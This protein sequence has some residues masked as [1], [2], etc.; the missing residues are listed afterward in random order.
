MY[1]SKRSLDDFKW[2]V[3]DNPAGK[4]IVFVAL[5]KGEVVGMQSLVP[6]TFL[7]N[8]K[9][10]NT[11]KS[12]D[13]LVNKDL[14]GQGIFSKLYDMVH[15]YAKNTLVWGLTDKK[16]ILERVDMPS[17]ER[18]TISVAVKRPLWVADRQG[19][20]QFVAKTLLYTYFYL[21]STFKTKSLPSTF[22]HSEL[23]VQDFG[24]RQLQHFFQKL[25]SQYPMICIPR[26]DEA[27]LKWRLTQNPNLPQYKLIYAYNSANEIVI[28]SIIG[29]S[30]NIAYWQSFYALQEV[31]SQEKKAHI[32]TLRERLFDQGVD[33]IHAWFFQCNPLVREIKTIF[34]DSGFF[35]VRDG[36]WIVHNAS[37][38]DIDVHD[39]YFSPQLGIR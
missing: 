13:T 28:C 33:M 31:T 10:I 30:E 22:A 14:R 6:Y 9:R 24:N 8:G 23:A 17:S 19:L 4:A 29:I 12:E 2:L 21:R 32:I 34:L 36:L 25:S 26:M 38:S 5:L 37:K 20:H 3:E 7:R 18:L 39:L 27:Y 35:A 11:Y 1:Q 15:A 16:S